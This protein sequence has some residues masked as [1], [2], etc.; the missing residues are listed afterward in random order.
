MAGIGYRV[1]MFC[2]ETV[3]FFLGIK[4]MG[5]DVGGGWHAFGYAVGASATWSVAKT[6]IYCLYHYWFLRLF[7]M[8][9]E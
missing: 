3:L 9:E 2:C 7:K 6:G 1:F 4:T 5:V 8:G